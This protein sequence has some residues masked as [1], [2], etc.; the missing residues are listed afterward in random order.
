MS[1]GDFEEFILGELGLDEGLG[2][3]LEEGAA[4]VGEDARERGRI[5]T[6]RVGNAD[7][8]GQQERAV[9]RSGGDRR[10]TS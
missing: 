3:G 9:R 6:A 2:E 10:A 7:I 1:C 4:V 8:C 5:V